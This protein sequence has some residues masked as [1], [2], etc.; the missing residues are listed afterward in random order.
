MRTHLSTVAILLLFSLQAVGQEPI[1]TFAG[2]TG[3]VHSVSFSPDGRYALTGYRDETAKLW[4]VPA[5]PKPAVEIIAGTESAESEPASAVGI[6]EQPQPAVSTGGGQ[7]PDLYVLAIGIAEYEHPMWNL[8][9]PDDDA[10]DFVAA[11]KRQEGLFYGNVRTRALV[12]QA[13]TRESILN[14]IDWL[15]RSAT[16]K[17]AAFLF[18]S[19]H[20]AKD[21]RGDTYLLCSDA[22]DD[23]LAATAVP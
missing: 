13:A 1:R 21:Q 16:Y 20:G 3:W 9:Y 4:A 5:G 18:A 12:D 19:A 17:D 8:R 6:Y 14:G 15:E 11:C 2:H 10:R 7:K 23:R 22:D